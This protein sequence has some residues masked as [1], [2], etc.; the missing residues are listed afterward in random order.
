[1]KHT[2]ILSLLFITGC[3]VAMEAEDYPIESVKCTHPDSQYEAAITVSVETDEEWDEVRFTFLQ[4][5][6][7]LDV[8]LIEP[9]EDPGLWATRI[10]MYEVN[11]L[12]EY[13]YDVRYILN[14]S[15]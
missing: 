2:L 11:C 1:M 12:D 4:D 6:R 7:I 15:K 8:P 9:E 14:E 13:S 3:P 5:K 10:Q